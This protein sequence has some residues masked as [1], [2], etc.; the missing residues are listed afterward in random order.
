MPLTTKDL[1]YYILEDFKTI[2]KI[3]INYKFGTRK[4]V[5]KKKHQEK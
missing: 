4:E 2:V 1:N 3:N 5:L